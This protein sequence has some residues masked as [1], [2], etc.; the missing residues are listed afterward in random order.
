MVKDLLFEQNEP[1]KIIS[2]LG[3]VD[4][5]PGFFSPPSSQSIFN[6]LIED[7]TWHQ[8][9]IWM[10]GKKI[11]QPRLT[12]LYGNPAIPYS[13]SG[14]TMETIAWDKLLLDIK[15]KVEHVCN[16][17]FTHVL[18]NYYRHGQDSMGWHRDNE[19]SLGNNPVI[20]SLSFGQE[21]VFQFRKYSDKSEKKSITLGNGSLLL[22][23]GATQKYWEHQVP[24]R[25]GI[26]AGRINLT[27]RKIFP[28]K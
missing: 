3:D 8:E 14:I 18:L 11:M 9:P 23:Q 10:F 26:Q 28:P 6:R 5:Y 2:E 27:F 16:T 17:E 7:I 24:K 15:D 4:Y 13:Y 1:L 25:A 19:K 21:R 12:A 22:M 20:A